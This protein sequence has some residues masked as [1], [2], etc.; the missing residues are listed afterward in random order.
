[1]KRLLF[2]AILLSIMTSVTA[3]V[4]QTNP[5]TPGSRPENT[6][7]VQKNS[8]ISEELVQV[9]K[10]LKEELHLYIQEI[11]DG[12]LLALFLSLLI[13]F[14]FG[15]FHAAGPGH[16]KIVLFSYFSANPHK[17]RTL[18]ISSFASAFIHAASAILICVILFATLK[19]AVSATVNEITFFIEQGTW[20]FLTLF[21]ITLLVLAIINFVRKDKKTEELS[22]KEKLNASRGKRGALA[23]LVF[24][25]S[26][27]PCPAASMIMILTL[28]Q[29][30]TALG[31]A[32]VLALS[33]GMGITI[34]LAAL[35][36]LLPQWGIMNIGPIKNSKWKEPILF[37][38]RI[39]GSLI[40]ITFSLLM[41]VPVLLSR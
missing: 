30:V 31:V 27:V 18:I 1:M 33:L 36:A 10:D 24:T 37:A 41:S 28:Q 11:K 26:I 40:L 35:P 16:R 7:P 32:L 20:I 19:R 34:T 5:F 23:L 38:F 12:E 29:E 22:E 14:A 15:I 9:Q 39:A 25:T 8:R 2:L 21:G 13:A 3:L 17:I 4:A 6:A